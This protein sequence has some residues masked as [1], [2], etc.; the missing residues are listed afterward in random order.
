MFNVGGASGFPNRIGDPMPDSSDFRSILA[1]LVKH[2]QLDQ[3][4]TRAAMV[5]MMSGEWGQLE[6]SAF[7]VAMRMKGETAREIAAAAAFL[8]EHMVSFQTGRLDTLDTCGTGGK[9]VA[10][11]NISSAAA[12][13]AA[14]AGVPVV[15]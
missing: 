1:R 4:M 9:A 15:K 7:L 14:G 11:L 5:A 3:H 2:N 8:R 13:V 10:T 6:S 12:L